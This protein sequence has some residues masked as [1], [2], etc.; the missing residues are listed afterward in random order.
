MKQKKW[1]VVLVFGLFFFFGLQLHPADVGIKMGVSTVDLKL[2]DEIPGF[3]TSSRSEFTFGAF[4]SFDLGR[5]LAVQPEVNYL[6]KGVNGSEIDESSEWKF[7]YLEIPVLLKCR[8]PVRGNIQPGVFLGPYLGINTKS[9]VTEMENDTTEETDLEDFTESLDYGL[10]FGGCVE[11][12]V[13]FGKFI[14]DVR[15]VLGLA[16]II[17]N[18]A[19]LTEGDLTDDDTVKNR[20]FS[21]MLGFCF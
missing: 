1:M 3:T 19:V 16:N 4:V 11:Y 2:S 18:L 10:V 5:F 20:T 12:Q 9:R 14:L 13:G 6:T 21:V 17:K 8:I 15:Y 7:T